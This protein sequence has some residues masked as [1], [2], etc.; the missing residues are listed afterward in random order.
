MKEES[1]MDKYAIETNL[2]TKKY[3][4]TTAVDQI[5]LQI[6]QGEIF[7]LI[8]ENGAGK[9]TLMKMLSGMVNSTSGDFKIF[10]HKPSEDK[11][12]YRRMGVLI[13]EAG[14]LGS[15]TAFDNI[16]DCEN[17]I[18]NFSKETNTAFWIEDS[19]GRM[20]YPAEASMETSTTSADCTVTFDEDESF[21]DMQPFGETTTNFYPFTLKNGTAYAL[22][23]QT[24][25]FVV[26]QATK[27]L[28][29]ILPYVILMIFLLSLLCAWILYT[30][31]H[32]DLLCN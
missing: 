31:Y 12:L 30:V 4:H 17:D 6:V 32:L 11:Y 21:I 25:L 19:N 23:V 2:L 3:R 7:G 20:I 8:G 22:A 1:K 10:G 26:Q 5:S 13:E 29:S 16:S 9:S 27:V 18:S 14:L 15:M 24:D 28:L